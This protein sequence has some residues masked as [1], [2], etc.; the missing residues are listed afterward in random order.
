MIVPTAFDAAPTAT[1]RVFF[2]SER[3][4]RLEV[5]LRGP[6]EERDGPDDDSPFL[7]ER[8]PRVHVRVVVE[9]GDDDL[10]ARRPAAREGAREVERQRRHVRAEGDLRRV[11]PEEIR[12]R[13]AGHAA[14]IASVSTLVG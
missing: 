13:A 8:A 10:V 11:A 7:L 12:E 4:E 3:R 14:I 1:S 9:L 2:A 6:A 5:E